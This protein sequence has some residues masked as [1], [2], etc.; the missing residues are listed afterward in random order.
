MQEYPCSVFLVANRVLSVCLVLH[1]VN[2]QREYG[3]VETTEYRYDVVLVFF[4]LGMKLSHD[5]MNLASKAKGLYQL[6]RGTR[7]MKE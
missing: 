2:E 3:T 1:T 7:K 5:E 6:E 4:H